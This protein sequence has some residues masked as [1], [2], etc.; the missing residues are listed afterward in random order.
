MENKPVTFDEDFAFCSVS[1]LSPSN[2]GD[3]LDG[4][5]AADGLPFGTKPLSFAWPFG[6]FEFAGERGAFFGGGYVNGFNL[7]LVASGFEK[8]NGGRDPGTPTS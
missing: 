5:A 3:L 8:S 1:V 6:D 7:S 2:N 4:D